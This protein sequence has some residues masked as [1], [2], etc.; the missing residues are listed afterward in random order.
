MKSVVGSTPWTHLRSGVADERTLLR[1][2]AML[3]GTTAVLGAIYS[4]LPREAAL[5]VIATGCF[6]LAALAALAAVLRAP[7]PPN[8]ISLW[9]VAGAL[10]FIGICASALIAPEQLVQIVEGNGQRN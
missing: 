4:V 1:G 5:P 9:D 3:V 8:H 10:T 7:I 2:G 6:A